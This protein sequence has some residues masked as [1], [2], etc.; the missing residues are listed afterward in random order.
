MIRYLNFLNPFA[1][2]SLF[3]DQ[4]SKASYRSTYWPFFTAHTGIFFYKTQ[5]IRFLN[6]LNPFAI[7]SLFQ[8]QASKS[9]LTDFIIFS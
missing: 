2:K 7:K 8:D 1:I 4:A 9:S 6:F 5:I 3:Q